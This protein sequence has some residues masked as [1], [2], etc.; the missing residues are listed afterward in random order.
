MAGTLN[1]SGGTLGG[2]AL[3]EKVSVASG[4]LINLLGD[5]TLDKRT[6]SNAGLIKDELA[7]ATLYGKNSAVLDN[8]SGG[9]IDLAASNFYVFAAYGGT[10][11][12]LNLNNKVGGTIRK[13]VG[14]D[15]CEWR[16][17]NFSNA[18][19]VEVQAGTLHL[20]D[21][22]GGADNSTGSGKFK[23]SAD[24]TVEFG[25]LPFAFAGTT[26]SGSGTA[27][28]TGDEVKVTT[29]ATVASGAHLQINSGTLTV[30]SNATLSIPSGAQLL[31]GSNYTSVLTHQTGAKTQITSGGIFDFADGTIN[32]AGELQVAG[33]LNWSGGTLQGTSNSE[34]LIVLPTG[35]LN[36]LNAV[37]INNRSI[38]NQGTITANTVT[39]EF[40]GSNG[41]VLANE[42][43][44]TFDISSANYH[45]LASY[46]GSGVRL[47][48]NN[49]IGATISKRVGGDTCELR[50]VNFTNSGTLDVQTGA[51]EL[52]LIWQQC[53]GCALYQLRQ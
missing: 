33:T 36:L 8:E 39:A 34:R 48:I 21:Y 12:P 25:S 44:A 16:D 51:L 9:L 10:G 2:A 47:T 23:T 19:L 4:G 28:I 43:G 40:I 42:S 11:A 7:S 35:M 49:K 46:G 20:R 50:D 41:A 38:V 32:G 17:V 29:T 26:F 37:E 5:V 3:T 45:V 1:W 22:G 15:E 13:S 53:P 30:A 24:A 18:G 27:I 31:L 14:A 6:L 52:R